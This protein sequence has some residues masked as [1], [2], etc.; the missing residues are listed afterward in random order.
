MQLRDQLRHK[1][2]EDMFEVISRYAELSERYFIQSE[3][4]VFNL[5][6][7]DYQV[8]DSIEHVDIISVTGFN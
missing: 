4:P 8:K 5:V 2:Y 6:T 7:C 3:Y 1:M